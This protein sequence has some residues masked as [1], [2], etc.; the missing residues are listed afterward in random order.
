MVRSL[1]VLV[2][3]LAAVTA[4][5]SARADNGPAIVIPSRPGIPIVINGVDASWAVVEGDW[6][7]FRPGHGV[8]TVIG[9]SPLVPNRVYTRRNSYLPR[10]GAAPERGRFE[11]E[12]PPDRP[13]PEQAESYSRSW[14]MQSNVQPAYDPRPSDAAPNGRPQPYDTPA[15]AVPPTITDPNAPVPPIFVF[16]EVRG[17]R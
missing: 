7:L 6:G 11:V 10:Y 12:P 8:V 15:D 16:P 3:G 2:V 5:S 17:R 13:L 14:G 4:A 9:G 1:A